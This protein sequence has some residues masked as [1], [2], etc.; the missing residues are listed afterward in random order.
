[1]QTPEE[2]RALPAPRTRTQQALDGALA[3]ADLAIGIGD[4]AVGPYAGPPYSRGCDGRKAET[5]R[6]TS[7]ARKI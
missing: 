7:V 3:A 4:G 5:R 2:S 1:M 6:A